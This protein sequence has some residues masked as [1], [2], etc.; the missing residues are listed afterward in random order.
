MIK[1]REY[2]ESDA[3]ILR[4]IFYHTVRNVNIRDY[5]QEQVEAWAPDVFDSE[6]WQ[7]RMNLMLPFVAEI[8]GEIV[9]YADLQ[10]NGLI[11]H[12][13]CHHEH[14]RKGI[15]QSLMEHALTVGKQQGVSKFYS[16]V[17]ITARPFYEKHGFKVIQEKI[18][19]VRGQK[20][21]NFIMEKL[22]KPL[23]KK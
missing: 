21:H 2:D 19:E 3:C 4:A 23:A 13:F 16:K 17:S 7:K 18:V 9:G 10:E 20:L 1:I 15:G 8:N 14:Q 22:S 5:S 6:I 11:D 12:F